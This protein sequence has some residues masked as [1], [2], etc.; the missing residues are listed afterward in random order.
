[1]EANIIKQ[2]ILLVTFSFTT[3]QLCEKNT[4]D[5]RRSLSPA[6]QLEEA[7][8]NGLLD[9]LL[10]DII[11]KCDSGKRLSLWQIYV[12]KYLLELEL[13]DYPQPNDRYLSINTWLFIDTL[14]FN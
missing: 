11:Q 3:K 10:G 6:E 12:G 4:P 5:N 7:C 13:C 8:W 14:I 2:E 1:M 9:E